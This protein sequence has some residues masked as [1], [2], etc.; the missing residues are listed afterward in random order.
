VI[1]AAFV[2]ALVFATWITFASSRDESVYLQLIGLSS[3]A[4]VTYGVPDDL[5]TETVESQWGA[6]LGELPSGTRVTMRVTN[7]SNDGHVGYR[8]LIG[9]VQVSSETSRERD[10]TVT[11]RA[12]AP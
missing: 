5:R 10:G 3:R 8:I 2:A 9:A 7:V 12:V 11:C 6:D 1:V 4:R